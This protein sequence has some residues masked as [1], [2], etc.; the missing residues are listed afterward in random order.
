MDKE[1]NQEAFNLLQNSVE[2]DDDVEL[3]NDDEEQEESPAREQV[4]TP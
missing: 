2:H 1:P 4:V 3:D